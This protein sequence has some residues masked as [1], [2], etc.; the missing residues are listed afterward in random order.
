LDQEFTLE[1][2]I[3]SLDCSLKANMRVTDGITLDCPLLLPIGTRN[4]A[5]TLKVGGKGED[6]PAA[7]NH[8]HLL[9]LPPSLEELTSMGRTNTAG[10]SLHAMEVVGCLIHRSL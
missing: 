5:E 6:V 10:S 3:G 8:H 7:H 4:Y 9:L 1:D 2:A